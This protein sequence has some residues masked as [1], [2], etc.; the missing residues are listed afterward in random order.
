[1]KCGQSV[2]MLMGV[3]N[4][5]YKNEDSF[6]GIKIKNQNGRFKYNSK[7]IFSIAQVIEKSDLHVEILETVTV[8]DRDQKI[9]NEFI[10]YVNNSDI[11]FEGRFCE[12]KWKNK[13]YF[14]F[15]N[16]RIVNGN[17]KKFKVY[18]KNI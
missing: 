3:L 7:R 10:D 12:Y 8:D 16:K 15:S 4:S 6:A 11:K 9:L 1:M 5:G 18:A 13:T 14:Y 17:F 2:Y